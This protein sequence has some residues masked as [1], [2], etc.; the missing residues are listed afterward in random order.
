MRAKI[1]MVLIGMEKL[2]M[3]MKKVILL[4]MGNLRMVINGITKRE[5][6][7][8]ELIEKEFK[9]GILKEG[10]GTDE[11]LSFNFEKIQAISKVNIKKEKDGKEKGHNYILIK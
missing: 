2:N 7:E 10:H 11:D 6:N 3:L 1:L 9:R 4:L 5:N 8:G